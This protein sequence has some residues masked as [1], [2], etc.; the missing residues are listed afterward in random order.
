MQT[1]NLNILPPQAR[2]ELIDFYEFLLKKYAPSFLATEGFSED[3]SI[4]PLRLGDLAVK[5]FGTTSGID[6]N[7]PQHPPHKPL[8]LGQ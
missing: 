4:K 2:V 8:E 6:M 3:V 5:L 1:V 7:L